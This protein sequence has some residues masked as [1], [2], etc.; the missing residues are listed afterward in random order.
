MGYEIL[1]VDDEADIRAS[2]SGLLEDEGYR[3]RCAAS[4][5]EALDMVAER[6]PNVVLLDIWMEGMDGLEVLSRLKRRVPDLP[7]IMISGH[8]TIE[9]AVQATQKGA[10]DFIEKPPQA[11][12]LLLT[13]DRAVQEA[14]LRKE[15]LLLRSRSGD[16]QELLGVSSEIAKCLSEIEKAGSG[17]ANRR[18][19]F[20]ELTRLSN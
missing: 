18:S 15:N 3:T 14:Q 4:G 20:I 8:G 16:V 5:Q 2:I 6:M 13:C 17:K 7:I 19:K 12:R 11:D 1:I 10:Y 9:T